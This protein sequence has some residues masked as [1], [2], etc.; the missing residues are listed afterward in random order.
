METLSVPAKQATPLMQQY[1]SVKE[2]Y[3]EEILFFRLGD[4]YEMFYEDAMRAAPLLEVALTQRQSVPMCGIP[5]HA[6]TTYISK[7]IK[8]GI[9]VAIAE[10]L[11]DPKKTK[12]MVKRDVVRVVTPGT[13]VE[14]E[15]LPSKANNFLVSIAV[16]PSLKGKPSK[17]ALA[18]ADVS[19]GKLW[20]GEVDNDPHWNELKSHLATLSPSEILFLGEAHSI[21]GQLNTGRA[22][23]RLEPLLPSSQRGQKV[24]TL[25]DQV[26]GAIHRY[27]ERDHADVVKS[28]GK[29]QALPMV[30]GN[31]L[32]L[33]ETAVR[34][35]ELVQSADPGKA[36]PTLISVIDQCVTPLGSRLMRWWLLHPSRDLETVR[37]R[38]NQ[39]EDVL[40]NSVARSELRSTLQGVADIER[41]SVRTQ[42]GTVSPRDL[43]ALR[44][45]LGRLPKVR[46]IISSNVSLGDLATEITVPEDLER[47][48]HQQLSDTPPAKLIDGGVI[49]EGVSGELDD[50][51]ALRRSGKKWIAEMEAAEREK[52]GIG[53]L[54]VGYN[55]VFGY[56]IEVS[57][58]NISKVPLD[59][60]RKQ[61]LANGE[62]YITPA[63]KEQEEKIL[64]AEERIR[65]LEA[66]LYAEL[67]HQVAAFGPTLAKVASGVAHLDVISALAE[68]AGTQGYVR[69][70]LVASD[71]LSI[72]AGWHPVIAKQM[73]RDRFIPNDLDLK[74]NENRISIITGP[75]MA[76]KSTFLRQNALIVILAQM[77]SFVPAE[78]ATIGLVDKIFTRIGA[79]DRL[80][81]GQSTF[82]VEMQEVA[83]LIQNCSQQSL[84]ILD[85]VG[86]GTSTYDGVSIAW[87]VIEHLSKLGP[88]TL[89]A[90][91]YF[92]LTQLEGRLPGVFNAHATAKEWTGSDGRKQVVFLY[93]ILPGPADRS[94]GIHV[95]E[96]AGV[97]QVCI[98]KAREILRHLE[99]GDHRLSLEKGSRAGTQQLELFAD[100]PVLAELRSLQVETLTPLEALNHLARLKGAL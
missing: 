70:Q 92:E 2:R 75:N 28:L 56:Y 19:T 94:Y 74:S 8:A 26:T 10:Q 51:R 52:T 73:G 66:R 5:Y 69:P 25:I 89:F 46:E 38:H 63:L 77:G 82:M 47:V 78:S 35:L 87:A 34:H 32:F 36:G 59:W 22:V 86:R 17:W 91:H 16:L 65:E 58:T 7:L 72:Q 76:G 67:I 42:A 33:D 6:M 68:V 27:L 29:P 97:P 30:S 90:T 49:R 53:S 11:E 85:E 20:V 64:G 41:I 45:S 96:M 99:S 83:T 13:L 95:A 88:R 60:I 100:H 61:T 79:S 40:E 14:D 81:Q 1:L 57:K 48:L 9:S 21:L 37:S 80:A 15:L 24:E 18:A 62:R 4:F 31:T 84:L 44:H 71:E 3:P 12:G 55:D 93:Q 39:V 54:K 43:E 98:E 50:L 23:I